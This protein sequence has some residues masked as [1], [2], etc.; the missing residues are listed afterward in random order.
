MLFWGN[1]DFSAATLFYPYLWNQRVVAVP[2]F[3]YDGKANA[4]LHQSGN[5]SIAAQYF[6]LFDFGTDRRGIGV[7]WFYEGGI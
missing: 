4:V 5:D 3:H 1:K 2:L 6:S 7:A